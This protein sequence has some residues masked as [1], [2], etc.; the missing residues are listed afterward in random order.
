MPGDDNEQKGEGTTP[1]VKDGQT[2]KQT[3]TLTPG[4]EE[5]V[6]KANTALT[7]LGRLEAELRSSQAET[8]R[9]QGV[10]TAA[11]AQA[12][13]I[14]EEGYRK[15][16]RAAE[17]DDPE[18]ARIRKRRQDAERATKLEERETKVQTQ[19]NKA[20]T[21]TAKALSG[22]YNI[23][24]EALLKYAGEDADSM[25][26]LAKSYGERTP[27]EP[28][29]VTRMTDPPESGKT[30]GG[31]TGLTAEDVKKMSPEEQNR[32]SKEIAQLPL[33]SA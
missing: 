22:Q 6:A 16:E 14:Q 20:M 29:T 23:N 11:I 13:E 17:G 21:A 24:E 27:G 28:K 10:A 3:E 19:L 33:V 26:E 7:N 9:I 2:P 18:L 30:I 15:E 31:N 1:E 4:T 32:R 8:K 12:K 5:L 25:E